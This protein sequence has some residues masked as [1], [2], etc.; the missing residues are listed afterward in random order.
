MGEIWDIYD[1][2]RHKTGRIKK[3]GIPLKKGEYH[4]VVNIWIINF[5]NK[6][7]LTQRHP[8]K[9]WGNYWECTGGAV[10]HGEDS[11]EGAFRET[12]EEI[13]IDLS[14]D[15]GY[16]IN[17]Y[18]CKDTFVDT[19][20]FLKNISINDIVLQENEVVNAKFVTEDEYDKMYKSGMIMPLIQNFT[21]IKEKFKNIMNK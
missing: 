8:K 4:I 13:G 12:R 17:R 18:K 21:E 14:N 9:S 19:W 16:L 11:L 15:N 7:L 3:R 2:N 20:I 10:M 5:E 1:S 6:I